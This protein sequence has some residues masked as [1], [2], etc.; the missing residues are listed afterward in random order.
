MSPPLV[1]AANRLPIARTADGG[2]E[3]SPG[4]LVRALLPI[5]RESGGAWVGWAGDAGTS[6]ADWARSFLDTL[7]DVGER[8]DVS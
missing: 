6:V 1:V 7:G 8:R 5:V 2:W 4:G 3:T